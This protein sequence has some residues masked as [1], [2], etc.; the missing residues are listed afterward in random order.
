MDYMAFE[1]EHTVYGNLY[2]NRDHK[3]RVHITFNCGFNTVN[4][5]RMK[6][7]FV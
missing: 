5:A 1:R 3:H 4:Q 7:W 6:G 2:D